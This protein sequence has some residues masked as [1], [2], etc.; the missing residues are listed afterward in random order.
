M[1]ALYRTSTAVA[2]GSGNDASFCTLYDQHAPAAMS[3]ALRLTENHALAE[4]AVQES[5]LRV[6]RALPSFRPGNVRSWILRIVARVCFRLMHARKRE[7][8]YLANPV[9]LPLYAATEDSSECAERDRMLA[10]LRGAVATLPPLDR[11]LVESHFALR[12]SQR[13]IS[14]ATRLPQQTISYRLKRISASLRT[15]LSHV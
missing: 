1:L 15:R 2:V 11:R 6:W 13:E 3:L 12:Q 14:A 10:A 8:A 7:R 5:M 4:D 9:S